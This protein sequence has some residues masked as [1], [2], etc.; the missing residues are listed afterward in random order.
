ML[1]CNRVFGVI[2]IDI[3]TVEIGVFCTPKCTGKEAKNPVFDNK[4]QNEVAT[5]SK[6]ATMGSISITNILYRI[7]KS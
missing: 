7:Y 6:S 4:L 3:N 5:Y 1:Q 2:A